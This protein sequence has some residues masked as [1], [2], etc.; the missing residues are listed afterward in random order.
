MGNINLLDMQAGEIPRVWGNCSL[1]LWNTISILQRVR[2]GGLF[3]PIP[4][5]IHES[6]KTKHHFWLFVAAT[7][8]L[9][10]GLLYQELLETSPSLSFSKERE[11]SVC[12]FSITTNFLNLF[13]F[14]REIYLKHLYAHTS[15]EKQHETTLTARVDILTPSTLRTRL[16]SRLDKSS[17]RMPCAF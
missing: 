5:S 12:L 9:G 3:S 17:I 10:R 1:K 16:S 14:V 2:G 8:H 13:P 15:F 11:G 6:D 7:P 4:L